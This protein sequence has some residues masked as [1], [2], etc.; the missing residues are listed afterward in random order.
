M[1]AA[2]YARKSTDQTGVSEDQKSVTRQI[3]QAKDYATRKGWHVAEEHVYAD[4]GVSGAE[5]VKRPGFIRLMTSLKPKPSFQILIMSEESRLGREQIKTAYALQQL[6]DAGVQVWFYLS[7]EERKLDTAMDKI[8]GSLTGFASE[9]ER[10]KAQQRTYDTIT[11]H[12]RRRTRR[13]PRG[14]A[15]GLG[16]RRRRTRP[17]CHG[18]CNRRLT[19]HVALGG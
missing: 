17:A 9:V 16:P 7:D 10:E 19:I 6:T 13:S 14:S 3:E 18:H 15:E 2:I 4:D 12:P 8:M 11:P 5:F 1:I